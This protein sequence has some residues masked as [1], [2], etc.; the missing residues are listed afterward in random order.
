MNRSESIIEIAKALS[1][2]QSEV[3][4]PKNSANN[5]MFKSKYAPLD[6]VINTIKPVLAK[7]GLSYLQSTGSSEDNIILTTLVMHESG[8]WIETDPLIL[9]GYQMRKGGGKEFNAQGAGSSI[10]YARRYQL[11]AALGISSEDDDDGNGASGRYE[12]PKG[13]YS[14]NTSSNQNKAP[15]G[16]NKASDK[17]NKMIKAK[18]N[19]IAKGAGQNIEAVEVSLQNKLGCDSL[20]D[21]SAATASKAIEILMKWESNYV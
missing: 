6:V 5:P 20:K 18:M 11:T 15:G 12:Q 8:E 17:Q 19:A 16:Q 1:K 3:E 2:F 4:N 10:T 13:N 9:P 14:T 21:L 7:N